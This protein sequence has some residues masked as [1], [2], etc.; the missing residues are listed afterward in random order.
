MRYVLDTS[1]ALK[2]VL[3]EPDSAQAV[4]LCAEAQAGVHELFAPDI[5]PIEAAHALARAERTGRI[6]QGDGW[7]LWQLLMTDRPTLHPYLPLMTRA[8]AI[9]S[10]PG[11]GSTT[12]CMSRSPNARAAS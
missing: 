12:A 1:V 6:R 11:S 7:P 9:A 8:F 10:G 4:R 3:P 2:V 5:F